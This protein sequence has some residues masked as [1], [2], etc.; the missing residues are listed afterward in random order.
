MTAENEFPASY[1]RRAAR[2]WGRDMARE[3]PMR[4]SQAM[5]EEGLSP[6][7]LGTEFAAGVSE[8]TAQELEF[9]SWWDEFRG[10]IIET[11]AQG[12]LMR[13]AAQHAWLAAR[14]AGKR[15]GP[16]HV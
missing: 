5:R 4:L 15:E 2:Q 13:D 10:G 3:W 12:R 7:D 14:G 8:R 16:P 6:G 11:D 1:M 9:D